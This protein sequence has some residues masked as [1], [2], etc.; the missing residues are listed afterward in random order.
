MSDELLA[1]L[2][3]A[4]SPDA[5]LVYADALQE[6]GDPHG[7]LIAL[8]IAAEQ[9]GLPPGERQLALQTE[10]S[11]GLHRIAKLR[12]RSGFVDEITLTT[13]DVD[14]AADLLFR[15]HR[16]FA[17]IPSVLVVRDMRK[18]DGNR[19]LERLV[20]ALAPS[21]RRIE[22]TGVSDVPRIETLETL[23]ESCPRLVDLAWP[24]R[25]SD[26]DTLERH[27][28]LERLTLWGTIDLESLE[29][30]VAGPWAL[31]GLVVQPQGDRVPA[32]IAE[33][34]TGARFPQLTELGIAGGRFETALLAALQGS[35]L[36]SRLTTLALR[37]SLVGD[38]AMRAARC[39]LE[40]TRLAYPRPASELP[41]V[42]DAMW[43]ARHYRL[44]LGRANEAIP[45]AE[46]ATSGSPRNYHAWM[47][48]GYA[49]DY[50]ERDTEALAAFDRAIEVDA[51]RWYARTG[52]ASALRNLGRHDEA[53]QTIRAAL[54]VPTAVPA[55]GYANL[56]RLAALRD[57]LGEAR[58]DYARAIELATDDDHRRRYITALVGWL[59]D[60]EEVT[61]AR[62]AIDAHRTALAGDDNARRL[63]G[64]LCLYERDAARAL[65]LARLRPAVLEGE[66]RFWWDLAEG[67]ALRQLG[68]TDEA[69]ACYQ[70][71]VDHADCP[72]WIGPAWLGQ[73]LAGADPFATLDGITPHEITNRIATL[74]TGIHDTR[75]H[76]HDRYLV[77][78]TAIAADAL[79]GR[80]DRARARLAAL[81]A[82]FATTHG[83]PRDTW[84][85][86]AELL[87]T[88]RSRLDDDAAE[89]VR[90]TYR[91]VTGRP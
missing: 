54:E 2:I 27:P 80:R 67:A 83:R 26:L 82:D 70:R 19:S 90:R 12:W 46:R 87:R 57:R 9:S 1:Q 40:R 52:R 88:A 62:A 91:V 79:A 5:Y 20:E 68:R 77:A 51:T 58:A 38:D 89:L 35:A 39:T 7:E 50:C 22:L 4:P 73:T 17:L 71:V 63:E 16:V 66:S 41:P 49:F 60:S 64:V 14:S 42:T 85:D 28:R 15:R 33:I 53:E 11:R 3:A 31:R 61:A 75:T 23:L 55:E 84:L 74:R 86:L 81:E 6:R 45:H 59:L 78:P 56:A 8:S 25:S 18:K 72:A 37:W 76:A 21:L 30:L 43:L 36:A 29:R 69:R 10:L 32:P 47:E 13:P 34:L 44:G 65:D 24:F 48:L